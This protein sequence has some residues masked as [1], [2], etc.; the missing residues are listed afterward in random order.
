MAFKEKQKIW[1][2]LCEE[3]W[4][5]VVKPILEFYAFLNKT[6]SY[7]FDFDTLSLVFLIPPPGIALLDKILVVVQTST[8]D[9]FPH[10]SDR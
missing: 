4:K 5:E 2:H 6:F 3:K 1:Q 7:S 9:F 10:K 8:V